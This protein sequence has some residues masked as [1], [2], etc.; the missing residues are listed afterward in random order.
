M[1]EQQWADV[2]LCGQVGVGSVGRT[3]QVCVAV[4]RCWWEC[5]GV[6]RSG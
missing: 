5:A 3:G 1:C 6:V 2:S 4:G